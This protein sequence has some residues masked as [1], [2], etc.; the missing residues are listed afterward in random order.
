[1]QDEDLNEKIITS[2]ILSIAA[3]INSRTRNKIRYRQVLN[4]CLE[5]ISINRDVITSSCLQKTTQLYLYEFY[6]LVHRVQPSNLPKSLI[7]I[8]FL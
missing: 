2:L 6:I 5:M 7:N 1:M 4:N 8:S 3:A